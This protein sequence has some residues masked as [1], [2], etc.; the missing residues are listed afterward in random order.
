MRRD[1][2]LFEA[3]EVINASGGGNRDCGRIMKGTKRTG[4]LFRHSIFATPAEIGTPSYSSLVYIDKNAGSSVILQSLEI[5][6]NSFQAAVYTFLICRI[7]NTIVKSGFNHGEA[8]VLLKLYEK[9]DGCTKE[10]IDFSHERAKSDC[11]FLWSNKSRSY[12][13][14]TGGRRRWCFFVSQV[15]LLFHFNRESKMNMLGKISYV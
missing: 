9:R 4:K 10:D 15:L 5:I 13:H 7:G 11:S 14:S 2:R 12:Q 1:S 3:V 6:R 8:E